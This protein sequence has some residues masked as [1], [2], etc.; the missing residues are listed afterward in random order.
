VLTALRLPI[1]RLPTPWADGDAKPC[2]SC[3]APVTNSPQRHGATRE[4]IVRQVE[5]RRRCLALRAG[6]HDLK[7]NHAQ[8][9]AIV[10]DLA[11]GLANQPGIG[12]ICAAQIISLPD[13][14]R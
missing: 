4:Q 3:R 12:P 2:G 8:L 7:A 10:D 5:I 6:R 14:H 11:P 13:R 1:D 9:H